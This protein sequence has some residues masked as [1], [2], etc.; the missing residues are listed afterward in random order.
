MN[1]VLDLNNKRV[2][3]ISDDKKTL[4]LRRKNCITTVSANPDGTF[5]ISHKKVN[6]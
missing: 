3:D 4:E 1:Q 5:N 6:Q 2:F